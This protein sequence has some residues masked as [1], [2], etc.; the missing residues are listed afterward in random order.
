MKNTLVNLTCPECNLNKPYG[1]TSIDDVYHCNCGHTFL[2][3][4][5]GSEYSSLYIGP[6]IRQQSHYT[7]FKIQP[8]VFIAANK[9][10]YLQG[11]IIKYV[12]RA[13]LKNGVE[14]LEKAKHYLDMLIQQAKGEEVKP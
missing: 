1:F 5:V 2:Y 3:P 4:K 10:D 13:N 12:C 8:V 7:Q 14:D 11:N 9:L 6:D